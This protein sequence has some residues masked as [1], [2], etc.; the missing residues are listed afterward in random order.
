MHV[1][2]RAFDKIVQYKSLSNVLQGINVTSQILD[3]LL[4]IN[5]P[6]TVSD[7]FSSFFKTPILK[8]NC[9]LVATTREGDMYLC[10]V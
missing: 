2:G 5:T 4:F 6:F 8:K 3:K 1:N 9:I 7:Y 10:L